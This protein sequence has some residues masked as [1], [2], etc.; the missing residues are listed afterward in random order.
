MKELGLLVT[1]C[2]CLAAD[3]QKIFQ[4]YWDMGVD[5]AHIPSEWPKEYSTKINSTTPINVEFNNAFNQTVFISVFI[6][7][8]ALLRISISL[9]S[10]S[11]L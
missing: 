10:L 7:L 6:S 4:V 5:N 3:I 2:S 8:E 9:L 11:T 1:N